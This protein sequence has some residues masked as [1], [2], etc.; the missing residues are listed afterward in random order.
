M[1][2]VHAIIPSMQSGLS[3]VAGP[4][5]VQAPALMV[6]TLH[7][8]S[9]GLI[10]A[11]RR[12]GA[13]LEPGPVAWP[14]GLAV[15]R[16]ATGSGTMDTT[17][18]WTSCVMSMFLRPENIARR[19]GYG[20]PPSHRRADTSANLQAGEDRAK[21]RRAQAAYRNRRKVPSTPPWAHPCQITLWALQA[22]TSDTAP[23]AC[24]RWDCQAQ[25]VCSIWPTTARASQCRY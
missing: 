11:D 9:N 21:N 17:M 3:V 2:V 13:G 15:R 1:N 24:D 12:R 19:P 8:I 6:Y 10:C 16:P 25:P 20:G 18:T 14:Q 23:C 22:N 7:T 5:G 4:R